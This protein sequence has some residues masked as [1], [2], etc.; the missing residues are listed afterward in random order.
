MLPTRLQQ[1]AILVFVR[2]TTPAM[3][4]RSRSVVVLV[5]FLLTVARPAACNFGGNQNL[6]V[7]F[8]TYNAMLQ[9]C[10][11]QKLYS[12]MISPQSVTFNNPAAK[13]IKFVIVE[14]DQK[15]D[16]GGISAAITSGAVD[17]T[18]LTVQVNTT[19][20]S[21]KFLNNFTVRMFCKK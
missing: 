4:Y 19:P 9:E 10:F 8:G 5:A 20:Q 18:A 13:K 1:W 3:G 6:V 7:Q 17:S 21:I 16:L 15:I 2:S 11:F 12:G 14:T